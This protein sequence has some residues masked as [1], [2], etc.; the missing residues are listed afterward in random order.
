LRAEIVLLAADDMPTADI[1]ERLGISMNTVS[2]WRNRFAKRGLDGLVDAARSGAPVRISGDAIAR[3][4]EETRYGK[5]P[6]GATHWSS[7]DMATH[8]GVSQ[9]SVVRVW[10]AVGL[11]PHRQNTFKLSTDPLFIDKVIDVVGLYMNPP[12]HAAVLCVDEKTQIQA[13]GRTGPSQEVAP[14]HPATRTHDYKRQG[15]TTLFAAFDIITGKVIHDHHD[16]HR[17]DEWLDFLRRIDTEVP[18]ELDVHIVCD[19]YDT[20]KTAEVRAWLDE[21][22]RFHMHFTPTSA[23]WLN[24]VERWFSLVQN[25]VIT[26]GEHDSVEDLKAHMNTWIEHY[27]TAP[28]P[29]VWT[30]SADNIVE[31]FLKIQDRLIG[32]TYDSGH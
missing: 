11:K 28:K 20:H 4:V 27:N 26:R 31:K 19:N 15:T 22:Q 17:A 8:A 21:H 23:S 3:I 5:P 18:A 29:F 30:K 24:Q 14:G 32:R 12:E 13:L 25:K 16:R 6:G 2:K 1:A 10:Q 9:A 7:R